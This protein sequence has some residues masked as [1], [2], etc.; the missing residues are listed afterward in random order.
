MKC[1]QSMRKARNQKDR[2]HSE[3]TAESK[4]ETKRMIWDGVL[5]R[6]ALTPEI[7]WYYTLEL[8]CYGSLILTLTT[9]V[10]RKDFWMHALH[11]LIVLVLMS[12]TWF[13]NLTRVGSLTLILHDAADPLLEAS[14]FLCRAAWVS[15][16]K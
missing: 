12:G 7:W 2:L 8:G 13:L 6:Q 9:D 15:E 14:A 4:G 5:H 3:C 10:R 16:E 1:S 11:H